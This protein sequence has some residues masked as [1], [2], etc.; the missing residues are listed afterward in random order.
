MWKLKEFKQAK[1][2]ILNFDYN[3]KEIFQIIE[4][5][6]NLEYLSDLDIIKLLNPKN[7]NILDSFKEAA[8]YINTIRHGK[9]V[10]FYTP[11]YVSNSCVNNCT[12]C[13]FRQSNKTSRV[14]L[15]LEQVKQE[16]DIIKNMGIEHI[17]IV[18]GEDPNTVNISYLKQITQIL[19]KYF[20]SISIEISPLNT[21]D[22]KELV[23]AGVDGL[24][25]YQETYDPIKYKEYHV[26]GPKSN[27]DWRISTQSRGG[28]AGF[29]NIILGS[30]LGLSEY[31]AEG[32]FFLT[33]ARY[34]A[35]KYWKTLPSISFPRF[36][37]YGGDFIPKY[38]VSDDEMKHLIAV[39]RLT[40]PDSNL[41]ISTRETP[42][43]REDSIL[44]GINQMSAGSKT[45]PLG[46]SSDDTEKQFSVNDDRPVEEVAEA[47]SKLGYEPVFKNWDMAFSTKE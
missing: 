34:L 40:L 22:Y 36:R 32:Y 29:R 12:Y 13:G 46:Y 21:N 47:I 25:C 28:E 33:H 45:N 20:S 16:V 30:L 35:K 15:S 14:T 18:A 19:K 44:Y 2:E 3:K 31:Y 8:H 42:A 9:T 7:I 37:P 39:S 26:S 10:N 5:A 38:P 11:I 17:L 27:F 6:T 24:A 41:I 43:F 4:K 23:E 1:K